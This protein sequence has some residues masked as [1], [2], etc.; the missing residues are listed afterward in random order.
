MK[1]ELGLT[2]VIETKDSVQR[3]KT[4][5]LFMDFIFLKMKEKSLI[6][7]N[8]GIKKKIETFEVSL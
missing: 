2:A 5:K 7:E 8:K 1:R 4:T 6:K 3:E